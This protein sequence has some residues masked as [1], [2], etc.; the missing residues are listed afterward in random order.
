MSRAGFVPAQNLNLD[1]VESSCAVFARYI[2]SPCMFR[3]L[4]FEVYLAQNTP[5]YAFDS[6][7]IERTV[8]FRIYSR[9]FSHFQNML[10]DYLGYKRIFLH[11]SSIFKHVQAYL[12]PLYNRGI[13]RTLECL[14][15]WNIQKPPICRTERI[16]TIIA[17][18]VLY[19]QLNPGMF[20]SLPYVELN[21]CP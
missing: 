18:V 3:T 11:Y 19:F 12:E 8:T 16:S 17:V 15:S 21:T 20:R 5:L 2:K 1:F 6:K 9:I 10:R 13:F 4:I 14:E 7:L